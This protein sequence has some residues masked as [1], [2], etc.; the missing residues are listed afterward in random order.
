MIYVDNNEP[1]EMLQLL[2]REG[3]PVQREQLQFFDYLVSVRDY[4]VPV[5]RKEVHDFVASIEDGRI[6]TQAYVMSSVSE[7]SF[8]VVEGSPMLV[9]SERRFPRQ[10]FIGAL[11]SLVLK[12]S[13]YGKK[14]FIS[15][16]VLDT[17]YDTVLFLKYLHKQLE[18]GKLYRL[19]RQQI[20]GKK[21]M[22]KKGVLI[23]MLQA[24]PGIGTELAYRIAE[25]FGSIKRL[26][27]AD[28]REIAS[29][30]GVGLQTAKRIKEYLS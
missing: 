17:K 7:I 23:A 14:G 3:L 12:R 29:V 22:N 6:F 10:A 19:P 30:P 24:V 18:E 20:R 16:V 28:V 21:L 8:I 26:A 11:T 5:E 9:L 15:L 25:H 27:E 2:R 4:E 13:P 1:E